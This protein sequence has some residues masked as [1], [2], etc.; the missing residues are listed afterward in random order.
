MEWRSV[1]GAVKAGTTLQHQHD[2][3][4]DD[5]GDYY[6]YC[7]CY[8]CCCY[9]YGNDMVGVSMKTAPITNMNEINT[10]CFRCCTKTVEVT[11]KK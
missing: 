9:D 5:V 3:D 6:Y 10:E 7:Y 2:D 1:A 11:C 4:D 8:C